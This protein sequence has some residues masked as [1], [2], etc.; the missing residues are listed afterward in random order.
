MQEHY[1]IVITILVV[2]E[3]RVKKV[4]ILGHAPGIKCDFLFTKLA[5]MQHLLLL[6]ISKLSRK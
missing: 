1:V 4:V 2:F 5:D 6:D 3:F